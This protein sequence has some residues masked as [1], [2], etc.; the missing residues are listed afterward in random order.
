MGLKCGELVIPAGSY[1]NPSSKPS[2]L[3]GSEPSLHLFPHTLHPGQG[4]V[5]SPLLER[6][7]NS[8]K[9]W[10]DLRSHDHSEVLICARPIRETQPWTESQSQNI[11]SKPWAF[12]RAART[13]KESETTESP[14]AGCRPGARQSD[15][16]HLHLSL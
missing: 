16:H 2:E 7:S 3:S 11:P 1:S 5:F 15:V 13:V 4:G 12:L 14:L 9:H 8:E 6:K 10:C